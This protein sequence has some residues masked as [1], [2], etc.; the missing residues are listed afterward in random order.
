MLFG[1]RKLFVVFFLGS[2]AATV[3][4]TPE[5]ADVLKTIAGLYLGSNAAIKIGRSIQDGLKSKNSAG[6]R[7]HSVRDVSDPEQTNR[8]TS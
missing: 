1:Y 4:L 6:T 3:P 2:I 8:E 7:I 5:Q